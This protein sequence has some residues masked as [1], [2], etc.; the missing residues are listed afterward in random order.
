MRMRV[1]IKL[2]S[3]SAAAKLILAL[4]S[5]WLGMQ[6]TAQMQTGG[7]LQRGL[8]AIMG[9]WRALLHAVAG[10]WALR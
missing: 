10:R 7:E 5:L 3:R 8:W 6:A 4:R 1:N 9:L 2:I